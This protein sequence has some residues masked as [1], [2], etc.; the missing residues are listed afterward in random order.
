MQINLTYSQKKKKTNWFKNLIWRKTN[1]SSTLT[2]IETEH[3]NLI[4][5]IDYKLFEVLSVDINSRYNSTGP[6]NRLDSCLI[7]IR[8]HE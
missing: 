3:D 8:N 5:G 7:I 2:E 6:L 4:R 1:I